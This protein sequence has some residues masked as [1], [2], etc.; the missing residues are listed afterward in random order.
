MIPYNYAEEE[1]YAFIKE[2]CSKDEDAQFMPWDVLMSKEAG[3]VVPDIYL[4][5]GCKKLGIE[6]NT[7]IEV[8]AN[9]RY[10]TFSRMREMSDFINAYLPDRGFHLILVTTE[11]IGGISK[12]NV[13]L[14][15]RDISIVY[16][17]DWIDKV[18]AGR[19]NAADNYVAY[20]PSDD[21]KIAQKAFNE[22][23]NTFFLGA[24]VSRS[25][26]LPDWKQLLISILEKRENRRLGEDDFK[27]MLEANGNSMIILARYIRSLY[28]EKEN[29]ALEQDIHAI[30]YSRRKTTTINSKTIREICNLVKR[31]ENKVRSIV[32]YNYD[33]LIEQQLKAI[34]FDAYSMYKMHEPNS[35]FPVCHVHGILGQDKKAY[36][37]IVLSE[38]DYHEQYLRPFL[39]SN[40][41]QLH[42]LQNHNCFFV[43]MSM[44]D[45][46]LRRLLDSTKGGKNSRNQQDFHCFAFLSKNSVTEGIRQGREAYLDRQRSILENLGVRVVWYD[47]HNELPDL[48][49]KLAKR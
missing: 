37:S 31:P 42:A 35:G 43:G 1:V 18:K 30:L 19:R 23:P 46:N 10:D 33:D 8:K 32:T 13:G 16:F 38:Q 25:E 29:G 27:K 41:E 15:G 12:I 2:Q 48:L 22:G 44:T 20:T 36:T 28:D 45:P 21:L 47:D 6:K 39:W 49:K 40:I 26:G 17:N 11:P 7:C 24:G 14:V 3:V 5:N 4:P 34:G 9:L